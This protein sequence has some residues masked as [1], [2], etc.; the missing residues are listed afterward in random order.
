MRPLPRSNLHGLPT[1]SV[2]LDRDRPVQPRNP[3]QRLRAVVASVGYSSH[4]RTCH[5]DQQFW[6]GLGKRC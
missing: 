4:L 2:Q 1:S 3:K 6:V 5:R